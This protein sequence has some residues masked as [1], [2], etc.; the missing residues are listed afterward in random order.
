MTDVGDGV[1]LIAVV[2]SFMSLYRTRKQHE[3]E[4]K[5]NE[6]SSKLAE[7]QVRILERE[8]TER[9][10]AIVAAYF[11]KDAKSQ[12]RISV[13]NNGPSPAHN[14]QFTLNI[15]EG[16][17]S[18]LIESDVNSKFPAKVIHPEEEIC[19]LAS[20]R[21]GMKTAFDAQLAWTNP[22][23]KTVSKESLLTLPG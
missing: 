15:P 14:V 21:L 6:M 22:D 3:I 20:I 13:R 4:N 1:A 5:Y 11:Y 7:L 16:Q 18:P 2:I 10:S 9:N 8:E 23:G 19:L 17:R 12:C